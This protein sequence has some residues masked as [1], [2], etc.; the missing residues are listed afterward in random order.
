MMIPS[1]PRAL[2]R[3][4]SALARLT[5]LLAVSPM[6]AAE[7][8]PPPDAFPFAEATIDQLQDRMRAGGL[9]SR[10]LTAAYLARIAAIDHAGPQLRSVIEINPDALALAEARDAER[11]A[12]KVR[13]PLHGIP[14]LLKDNIATADRMET[15]AGSL[16]L[17]GLRP[18]RDAALVTRLREAG[19]VILGKTN[20][21]EWANYRGERSISGW[22]ARGGQ[23]RNPYALDRN[24]SGS[25]SGSA[26]AVSANLGVVA[27][28]T[29]TDGSIMSPASKNGVV[30]VKPTVGLISRSGIIPISATQDTAGPMT[31]TVRD[32]AILLGVLAGA[33]PDDSATRI[34]PQGL[35]LDFVAGLQP[36][37]LRGARLGV[38]RR[39]FSGHPRVE[40]ILDRAII[41]LRSAGAVVVDRIETPD[42]ARMGPAE[43]IV[44]SYEFKDGINAWLAALGPETRLKTLA[45][46]IAFNET[47]RARELVFFGQETMIAA[48][49]RGALTE[50]E[51]VTARTLAAR[52]SREEG[53]DAIMKKHQ[54]DAIVT[55]TSG[56][57]APTDH[58]N[59]D[60]STGGSSTLAA[61]A[62]YPSVT[63]PAGDDFGLPVG[64]SFT[65]G[66]WT[67][68]R[69]LALAA[70]FEAQTT[71]RR[72]PQFLPTLNLP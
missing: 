42:F 33:D 34:R 40:A 37:A 30:G 64:L 16:A 54:L 55:L 43:R 11:A 25:S 48:Q 5:L 44:L 10:A 4:G 35:S 1:R 18:S 27:V 52:L 29:E 67:E 39:A 3:G 56:P 61:V 50:A 47:H 62:G 46:V 32:A 9:T 51:Y 26:V 15:T 57:A 41:A 2:L 65:G 14:V 13:G 36:G 22:S 68:A 63:V 23:T 71:A 66:A 45:D 17:V 12:G 49:A 20:L 19:A 58:V 28:G 21:S 60:R 8:V 53:I 24:P 69:L 6:P 31:R 72:V 59:G 7:P 70:D 38:M